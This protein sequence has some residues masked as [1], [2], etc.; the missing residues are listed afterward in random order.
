MTEE[1]DYAVISVEDVKSIHDDGN[2][3]YTMVATICG[4]EASYVITRTE[5]IYLECKLK[6][7]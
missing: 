1:R 2:Q 4:V 7:K 3:N 6:N 5:Y